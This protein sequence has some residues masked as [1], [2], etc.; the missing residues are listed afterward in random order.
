MSN[1]KPATDIDANAWFQLSELAVDNKDGALKSMLQPTG[2]GG[3]LRVWPAN[4]DAYW[5][6]QKIGNKPGRY[7]LRCSN[8]QVRKQLALC[9]R[10]DV[11]DEEKRTRPC[12]MPSDDSEEQQWDVSLWGDENETFRLTN[13]KNGTKWNLDCIPSGP[14]FMSSDLEGD[15]PRQHWLMSSVG[16]APDSTGGVIT[17][18]ASTAGSGT[19]EAT[20]T[21]DSSSSSTGASSGSSSSDSSESGSTGLSSGAVAGIAVG[22]TLAVV[23]LALAGFFFWRRNKR[24]YQ[25]AGTGSP[26]TAE[27]HGNSSMGVSPNAAYSSTYSADKNTPVEMAHEP[28]H[29]E[30]PSQT[31]RHELA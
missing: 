15:Q 27:K 5:Q 3:D 23:A 2:V 20:G 6:F 31:Q 4:V 24:K 19:T 16:K 13:V 7:Q 26:E 25:P 9:Y 29:A 30:L 18:T 1:L 10:P 8:T 14:V 22:A 11:I 21:S 17:S 28:T 12:L